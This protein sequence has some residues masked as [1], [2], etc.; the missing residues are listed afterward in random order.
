MDIKINTESPIPYYI[1]IEEQFRKLISLK[2]Y[3]EGKHLPTEMEISKRL[4]ISR[5]TVRQAINKLVYEGLIIRKKGI[6]TQVIKKSIETN[7]S[8]W[9][10]FSEEMHSLGIDF[11]NYSIKTYWTKADEKISLFFNINKKDS[12]YTLE[13]LRGDKDGPF[14]FFISYFHP[15]IKFKKDEDFSRPLYELLEKDHHQIVNRSLE[16]IK[17]RLPELDIAKKLKISQ[18]HP[19]LIRERR[20]YNSGDKPIELNIGYYRSDKFTYQIDIKRKQ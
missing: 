1:Q 13:R 6:G 16:K 9:S 19:I 17:A 7:L 8:D 3:Q 12:V 2:E 10:S 11:Q 14:V 15:Q 4:G 20:V 5:N 18:S